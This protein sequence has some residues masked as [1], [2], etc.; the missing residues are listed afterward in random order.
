MPWILMGQW[1]NSNIWHTVTDG[2]NG[3]AN[4]SKCMFDH[5]KKN[6][7]CGL[8]MK[9]FDHWATCPKALL[10]SGSLKEQLLQ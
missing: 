10:A 2:L 6:P 4:M 1:T 7:Y 8:G 3:C 9:D 5:E